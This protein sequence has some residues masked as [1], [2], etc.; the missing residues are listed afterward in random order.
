MEKWD[1]FQNNNN[2]K[3]IKE[4]KQLED[5]I[6]QKIKMIQSKDNQNQYNRLQEQRTQ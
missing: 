4:V 2:N 3:N 5:N 6:Y 1:G